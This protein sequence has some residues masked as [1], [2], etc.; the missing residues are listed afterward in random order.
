MAAAAELRVPLKVD[1][2][3][4][5]Q[6]GRGALNRLPAVQSHDGGAA[7]AAHHRS[8]IQMHKHILAGLA[9]PSRSPASPPQPRTTASTSAAAS[10][11]AACRTTASTTT[12][13]ST[14]F[15]ADR[16][17][18]LPGLAVGR[19]QLRRPRI[20][21]RQGRRARRSRPTSAAYRC[22]RSVS[23]RSG[24][25]DLFARAG[26]IDWSADVTAPGLGI[27]GSDD[28][29]DFTY[30]VGAQ[31]RVWSLSLR[32]EYELFDI[33]RRRHGRPALGRRDVDVPVVGQL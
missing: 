12:P 25:V 33:D 22:R 21:R 18:A 6:L 3:T 2:G 31:F 23:W 29:I 28:G 26:A 20:R 8:F 19:G 1:V 24:P 27:N 10:A 17:V 5:R 14:G 9:R 13:V 11:R 7:P 4:R 30:G 15:K 32:A 16:R